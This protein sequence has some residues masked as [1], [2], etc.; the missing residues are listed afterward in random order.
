MSRTRPVEEHFN[1]KNLELGMLYFWTR[2][3]NTADQN[4]VTAL[5]FDYFNGRINHRELNQ[6]VVNYLSSSSSSEFSN[7]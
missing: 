1:F 5:L 4:A 3:L 6:R 2:Y 7:K